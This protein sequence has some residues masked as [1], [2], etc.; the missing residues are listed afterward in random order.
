[1]QLSIAIITLNEETNLA[2]TL[3]SLEP[4]VSGGLGEIVV[5]DNGSTDGTLEVARRFG[6]KVFTEEWK[7]FARQKNSAIAKC[8]GEWVLALD[9]DEALEPA[10]VGEIQE[11]LRKAAPPLEWASMATPRSE[12]IRRVRSSLRAEPVGYYIP[13]KNMFLGK[14]TRHGG[15]YPDAKLRLFRRG[16]GQF[17]DRPVHEVV[18]VDGRTER[19]RHALV[20]HAY[21]TLTGYIDHMNRYSS[22]GAEIAAKKGHT[23]FSF[24][25]IVVRPVAT[26]V[27]KYFLKAGFLDGREGLLLSLYHSMYVSWKYAKAWERSRR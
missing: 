23:S 3:A 6:A 2:R 4:L 21:P 18:E 13:R 22:L 26:F 16:V 9:A 27:Q 19:L 25:N 8:T 7:G 10:L 5:V 14:W 15:F 20:H 17:V 1:M 11:L 12:A 24:L